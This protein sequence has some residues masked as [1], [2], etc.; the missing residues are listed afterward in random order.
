MT[1]KLI[2]IDAW[3]KLASAEL[4]KADISSARLDAELLLA[5][6][7]KKP[8][9]YIQAHTDLMLTHHQ[10]A[11]LQGLLEKRCNGFPMA[12]ITMR[13]EFYNHEFA[14]TED[15]LVPRPETESLVDEACKRAPKNGT[16]LELGTGSGCVAISIQAARNDVRVTATD[17]SAPALLVARENNDRIRSSVQFIQSDM[18]ENIRDSYDCIVANLPYIPQKK[19]I[20]IEAQYEPTQAIFGGADGLDFYRKLFASCANYCTKDAWIIIEAEPEQK[21]ELIRIAGNASFS[22]AYNHMYVYSWRR[23]PSVSL[24]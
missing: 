17:I 22:L 2:T 15:V 12:Y 8:R 16:V 6:V 4:T 19:T 9:Q 1:D 3:L 14:I 24:R 23:K 7:L 5:F 18:W 21:N 11:V 20:N 10:L 13:K